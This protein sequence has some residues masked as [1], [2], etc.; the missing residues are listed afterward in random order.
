MKTS[1]PQFTSVD[2]YIGSFPNDVQKVLMQL[3][4]T[5]RKELPDAEE[6]ISYNIPTYK[7]NGKYVIYFAGFAHHVSLYPL[8][9]VPAAFRKKLAP[10][11]S[12]RGTVRFSLDEPLPMNLVKDIVT[13]NLKANLQRTG[14]KK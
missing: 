10:Y 3:R 2:Q 12:G 5:I 6:V 11:L 7:M 8:L 4:K 14:K 9:T 1:R 13:L